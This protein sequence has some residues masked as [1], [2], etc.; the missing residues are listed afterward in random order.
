M[1]AR[2]HVAVIGAGSWGTAFATV[3]ASNHVPV[4]LWARRPELAREI[5]A[6]HR[7]QAYLPDVDLPTTIRATADLDEAVGPASTIVMAV[8]SH[9]FREKVGEL[10]PMIQ[11]S[12]SIASLTKGIEPGT[13]FRMSEV[14]ADAA[15][16]EPG[17]A[18]AVSGPNLAR[19][20]ARSLPCASVVACT[21]IGRAERLQR[22]FHTRTF[23]VYSN[24][25]VLGVEIAGACKNI[26][27][28]AAGMADGLGFGDNSKAAL[29]TRGLAE[30][31]RL[32]CALGAKP[33][34]FI[35]LAGV[36][37]MIATCT[38][39]QSRNRHVGEELG[40]GRPLA[41]IIEEMH[42]VAEGVKSC[43]GILG[44][45]EK[46][47]V[48]MPIASRVGQVLFEGAHPMSMVEDLMT[49]APEPEFQGII[50]A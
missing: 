7:N 26:I 28:L 39:R 41:E 25:D 38:S 20:V 3:V 19:E 24:E 1:S 11:P 18:A 29:I 40:K 44:L 43:P 27:A 45:A 6:R 10:A 15:R 21:E 4:V 36:G 35:G 42:M 22:L 17:R 46:T 13:L 48:E 47:G 23:R 30:V 37:D 2:G 33:I 50:G 12:A 16:V 31:A 8:P 32:G 49:R 34:T 14:I 5:N 9:A